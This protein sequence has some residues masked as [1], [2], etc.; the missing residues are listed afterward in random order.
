MSTSGITKKQTNEMWS[1]IER[2][3]KYDDAHEIKNCNCGHQRYARTKYIIMRGIIIC[4]TWSSAKRFAGKVISHMNMKQYFVK[5]VYK[6]N[7]RTVNQYYTRKKRR[8]TTTSR[9]AF[10]SLVSVKREWLEYRM[11]DAD[12]NLHGFLWEIDYN[13]FKLS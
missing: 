7:I 6:Y 3:Y 11:P 5:Y 2:Y 12:E 8:T 9:T 10:V 4:E 13:I 1:R